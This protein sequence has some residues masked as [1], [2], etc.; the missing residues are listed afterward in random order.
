[1]PETRVTGQIRD[2]N[3]QPN[4]RQITVVALY[5]DK[6]SDLA[7]L[8]ARCQ[9]LCRGVLGVGFRPYDSSQVHATIFGLERKIGSPL[10]NANFSRYEGRDLVMNLE[11]ILDYLRCSGHFPLEVQ[12]GGYG[13]R[14]YPFFS[15][16]A[17]P[18]ERSFTIQGGKVVVMGWPIRRQPFQK[19][20]ATLPSFVQE[21]R[22][23]PLTLE[24]VRRAAQAY[25]VLHAYH[26]APTDVDN[27]LFFRIGRLIDQTSLNEKLRD[28]LESEV[29]QFLSRQPPLILDI[30]LEQVSIVLYEEDTLS[31]SSTRVWSLADPD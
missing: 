2:Q 7:A 24:L 16:R 10:E 6:S 19:P 21:A 18:Y 4:M 8:I 12:I 22:L 3:F 25:G 1:M 20:P 27:D 29:R 9:E 15:R 26:R 23:Y 28:T 14:D 17:C 5:G 31:P 11:G 30:R 13:M